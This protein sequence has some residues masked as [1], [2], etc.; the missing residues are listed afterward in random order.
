MESSDDVI[1][2]PWQDGAA[3]FA[4][5][6]LFN[7]IHHQD[8]VF[9]RLQAATARQL[10][11][12]G[13]VYEWLGRPQSL[14]PKRIS[15]RENPGKYCMPS[16]GIQKAV[17]GLVKKAGRL[18]NISD[19]VLLGAVAARFELPDL[20]TEVRRNVILSFEQSHFDG[21]NLPFHITPEQWTALVESRIICKC[22]RVGK[23]FARCIPDISQYRATEIAD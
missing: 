22:L 2:A 1:K 9:R 13:E 8:E 14:S 19:W 21:Q 4:L 15:D 5:N 10:F 6:I 23:R 11:Y 3:E 20:K 7:R 18:Y 12:V 17:D 16:D